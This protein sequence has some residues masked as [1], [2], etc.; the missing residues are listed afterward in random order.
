M[1][2]L[3]KKNSV[4]NIDI[5]EGLNVSNVGD[6]FPKVASPETDQN[7]TAVFNHS[8]MPEKT[9]EAKDSCTE[10][11]RLKGFFFCSKTA[12]N[13]SKKILTEV[14]IK[15]LEKGL[16]FA[17][18]QKTLN[19]PELRKDF[20]E[21]SRRMGCKWNFR[22]EPTNN[23]SEIRTFRPKPGWKLPKRHASLE[24]FLS[25]IEKEPFSDEMNVST[26]NNLSGEEW[27]ALRNL[28]Y[29]RSIVIKGSDKGSSDRDDY[30]HEA[31]RQLRDTNIY[32]DVK[33]NGNIL[34]GLVERSNKIFNRLCG[35]K[36]ITEKELKYFTYSFKTAT[37]LGKLDFLPMIQKRLSS[38]PGRPVTSNYCTPTETVSEY[39]DHIL[40]PVMQKSWSYIKDSRDFLK[41]KI[42]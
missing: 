16:D 39:L 15:V 13:Q 26:Q 40:K 24:V 42:G 3:G 25:R 35:R 12:F 6:K 23:F 29:D 21:F 28:A 22:N 32:E 4:L 19:E 30:L 9:S 31:S 2:D 17:P 7:K 20:E 37:S 33:F 8:S 1:V 18:I 41:D 10:D 36:F 27:K 38:V 14:E 11:D 5:N 34:T